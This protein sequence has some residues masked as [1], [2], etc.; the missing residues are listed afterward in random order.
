MRSHASGDE[1]QAQR[2]GLVEPLPVVHHDE[3]GLPL[4]ESAE[5]RQHGR[6]DHQAVR[7][8]TAQPERRTHSG[9]LGRRQ[10]L[11]TIGQRS[12]Q[13]VQPRESQVRLGPGGRVA[14][15]DEVRGLAMHVAKQS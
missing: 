10:Q 9:G 6:P 3:H 8:L 4:G 5:E 11:D 14:Q 7:R 1:P 2:G 12:Q 15:P 13:P